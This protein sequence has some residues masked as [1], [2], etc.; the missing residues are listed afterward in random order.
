MKKLKTFAIFCNATFGQKVKEKYFEDLT[1]NRLNKKQEQLWSEIRFKDEE[2]RT[3]TIS[4]E[5]LDQGMT[6]EEVLQ[7]YVEN[8]EHLFEEEIYTI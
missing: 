1:K 7:D 8:C 6:F 4:R 5:F 3:I 2:D